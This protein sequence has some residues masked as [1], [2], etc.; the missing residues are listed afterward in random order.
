M[1]LC[2]RCDRRSAATSPSCDYC[3]YAPRK[4]DGFPSFISEAASDH[5]GFEPEYFPQLA[6]HEEQY[7]W[8]R[9]RA[10]LVVDAIRRHFPAAQSVLEIGCGTGSV[11]AAIRRRL[12]GVA[13]WGSDIFVEGL[14]VA[15]TRVPEARLLQFDARRVPFVEEFDVICA[16]DVLEHVLEDDLALSQAWQAIRPGGGIILT[17]PQH[18]TLWSAADDYARHKRRYSRPQLLAKV[19][20]A[21]FQV[22]FVSSFVSLLLPALWLRR[23]IG[24]RAGRT[25]EPMAEFRIPRWLNTGLEGVMELERRLIQRGVSFPAGGSLLVVACR[26]AGRRGG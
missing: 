1:K 9:A 7:F 21:R 16:L 10:R 5:D 25:F 11:L 26:E 24:A 17:V 14:K 4:V 12:P 20:Q 8:F 23:V 6:A 19:R 18:R 2:V 13:V 15:A 3:G 22:R